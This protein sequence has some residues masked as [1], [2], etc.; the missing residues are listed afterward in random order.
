MHL[1]SRWPATLA[2]VALAAALAACG[3]SFGC[4][5]SAPDAVVAFKH[6]VTS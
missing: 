1:Q 2:G 6:F 3:N 5:P 4:K